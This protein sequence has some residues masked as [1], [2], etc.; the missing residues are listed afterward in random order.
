MKRTACGVAM[1]VAPL[2]LGL[3]QARATDWDH[4]RPDALPA[5]YRGLLNDHT[6]SAA[7]VKG[8]PYE[9]RGKWSLEVDERRGTAKFSAQ[10]DMQTSD[11]GITQGNVNK[12]DPATRGAH[13]H[14]ISMTDGVLTVDWP[15]R[16][17]VF[18]PAVTE[19]FAI[20]GTAFVTGNGSPAP[21]G[22]P[23]PFTVCVLGGGSVK[24]SN[25]T[26]TFGAPA[27]NHFG[28]QPIHGV[29]LWCAGRLLRPSEDCSLEE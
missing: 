8:G 13:T 24:Y 4:G 17:P 9:M 3:T 15:A 27:S 29:V 23:S 10:M 21:F 22:N 11:F 18:S 2:A 1:L 20:T 5:H 28:T 6:P 12:D 16:C 19:G 14:H 25:V 7:V 26:V